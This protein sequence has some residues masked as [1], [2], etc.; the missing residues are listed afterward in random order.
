MR[1]AYYLTELVNTKLPSLP[2]AAQGA[3]LCFLESG[4]AGAAGEGEEEGDE[5]DGVRKSLTALAEEEKNMGFN[6]HGG[7]EVDGRSRKARLSP[8]G[9]SSQRL[10]EEQHQ[11]QQ[12]QQQEQAPWAMLDAEGR[13]AYERLRATLTNGITVVKVYKYI[14]RCGLW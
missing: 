9:G 4:F 8:K 12:H 1:L 11:Q 14:G 2:S 3:V 7:I 5:D 6:V 13:A 10:L